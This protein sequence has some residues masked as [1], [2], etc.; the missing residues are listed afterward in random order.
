MA[1]SGR[2]NNV[3]VCVCAHNDIAWLFVF[4]LMPAVFARD[5]AGKQLWHNNQLDGLV[6]LN[7]Y[8]Y[9][10]YSICAVVCDVSWKQNNKR[11]QT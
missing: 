9:I 6:W 2:I 1:H 10:V 7:L 8:I 4:M 11:V 3:C 5:L